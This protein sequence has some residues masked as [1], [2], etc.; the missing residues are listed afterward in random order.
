MK[1]TNHFAR[2]A[3]ALLISMM[4]ITV[5]VAESPLTQP[6]AD[7][8]IGEQANG[9]IGLVTNDV[10]ADIRQLV[11]EVNAK[12]KAG[13]QRI[14]TQQGVKLEDVELVGGKEAIEKTLDGNY[15]KDASGVWRKK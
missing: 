5:A 11:D 4:A 9:Y 2:L 13:Y 1:R 8:L 15:V 7:G 12:R 6:K 14:A 3:I 10:P